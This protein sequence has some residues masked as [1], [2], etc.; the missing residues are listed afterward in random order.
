VKFLVNI[1]KEKEGGVSLSVYPTEGSGKTCTKIKETA[2]TL[3]GY[4]GCEP[5]LAAHEYSDQG[6]NVFTFI[7][8]TLKFTRLFGTDES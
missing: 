3:G 1:H 2:H 6:G 8:C 5:I 4:I 7:C